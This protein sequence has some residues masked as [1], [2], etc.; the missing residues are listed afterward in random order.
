MHQSVT[1][2]QSP[3][4]PLHIAA[5]AGL[6]RVVKE[7]INK[8]SDLNARD[9]DGEWVELLNL[10]GIYTS[11]YECHHIWDTGINTQHVHTHT[12][13]IPALC[14]APNAEVAECLECILQ[15]MLGHTAVPL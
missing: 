7:L 12:D 9:T 8:G 10:L 14:C 13:N 1:H 5:K 2:C 6:V 11:G 4:S 3:Y 15:A